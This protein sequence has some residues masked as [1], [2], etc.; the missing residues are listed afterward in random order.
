MRG[1]REPWG[2]PISLLQESGLHRPINPQ[3]IKSDP[4]DKSVNN[5][6]SDILLANQALF[7]RWTDQ[8]EGGLGL[9]SFLCVGSMALFRSSTAALPLILHLTFIN[10]CSG[11]PENLSQSQISWDKKKMSLP[12][13]SIHILHK[14][15]CTHSKRLMN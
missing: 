2:T 15:K 9:A 5:A 6:S 13:Q 8:W 10:H 3:R 4:G 11:N 7:R 14:E 1:D 12:R